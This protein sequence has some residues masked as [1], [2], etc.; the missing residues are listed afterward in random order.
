MGRSRTGTSEIN[1]RKFIEKTT[2]K[3]PI[4][5]TSTTTQPASRPTPQTTVPPTRQQ[6]I[7][8]ASTNINAAGLVVAA[9]GASDIAQGKK[10]VSTTLFGQEI[11]VDEEGRQDIEHLK[12][13]PSKPGEYILKQVEGYIRGLPV[14]TSQMVGIGKNIAYGV[15]IKDQAVEESGLDLL[16]NPLIKPYTDERMKTEGVI[17]DEWY[18]PEELK[19]DYNFLPP[20]MQKSDTIETRSFIEGASANLGNIGAI[21]QAP[22]AGQIRDKEFGVSGE[23]FM[24]A[25]GYYVGTAVGEIPYFLIGLG[26]IKAV[27][28]VAAKTSAG[29][30]RGSVHGTTGLKLVR[31]AYAV[32]QAATKLQKVTN[33]G[34]KLSLTK[35]KVTGAKEIIKAKDTLVKGYA[36]N[37]ASQEKAIAVLEETKKGVP[38][39]EQG[40]IEQVIKNKLGIIKSLSD[41][42]TAL[43]KQFGKDAIDKINKIENLETRTSEADLFNMALRNTDKSMFEGRIGLLP[44]VK[45]FKDEYLL[46]LIHI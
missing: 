46:S 15:D 37:I 22:L 41:E 2:K 35:G 43:D 20:F 28:T 9:P 18:F 25:P 7:V 31:A 11:K 39:G 38:K 36:K 26:E 1:R 45:V 32:E 3:V 24:S 14:A 40:K 21:S 44:K 23:R 30:I 29:V 27:A 13:D 17:S 4:T 34:N 12:A 33:L 6:V 8:P 19:S 42:S 10:P 16:I 5:S